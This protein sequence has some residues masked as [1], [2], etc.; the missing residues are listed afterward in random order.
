MGRWTAA[1][2]AVLM[3]GTGVFF[4]ARYYS[5]NLVVDSQILL[6]VNPSIELKLN[7]NDKVMELNAKNDDAVEILDDMDLKGTDLNV[8]VNACWVP[9]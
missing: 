2:A 7:A 6:D 5:Q 3:L 9:W 4:G 1:A 8:A